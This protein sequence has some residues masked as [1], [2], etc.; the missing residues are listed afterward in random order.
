MIFVFINVC[1]MHFMCYCQLVD[2]RLQTTV[3]KTVMKIHQNKCQWTAINTVEVMKRFYHRVQYRT[4][5]MHLTSPVVKARVSMIVW[6]NAKDRLL[7]D[8]STRSLEHH[9]RKAL[10]VSNKLCK[11]EPW[12]DNWTST[13]C[14]QNNNR[15]DFGCCDK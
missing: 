12:M 6:V 11:T 8:G 9:A 14:V 5:A 3:E 7:M 2:L 4:I 13:T 1:V 15:P 10:A